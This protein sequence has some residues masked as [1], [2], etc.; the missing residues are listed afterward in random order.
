LV[1]I[2]QI[3]GNFRD[4]GRLSIE[5]IEYLILKEYQQN[6]LSTK[7]VSSITR[8]NISMYWASDD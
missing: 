6:Q 3:I 4:I 1:Y 2:L 5:S 7:L 8:K